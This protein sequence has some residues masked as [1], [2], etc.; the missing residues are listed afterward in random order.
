MSIAQL[1]TGLDAV[2]LSTNYVR[3]VQAFEEVALLAANAAAP[4]DDVLGL[5][6]RSMCDLIGVSRCSVYL[7]RKDGLFQGQAGHSTHHDIDARVKKLVAGGVGD[8]FTEE[9]V[10]TAAPVIVR[11]ATED[12]RTL[13]ATMLRWGVCD[14]LG[15]PL[16]LKGDVI[17]I[18][19][20][21]NEVEPHDYGDEDVA[22]A[23]AFAGL[24]ALVVHQAWTYRRL[25]QRADLIESQRRLL[26]ESSL[27]H[28]QVMQAMVNGAEIDEILGIIVQ[29][30]G[31]P[32][33][34]YGPDVSAVAFVAPADLRHQGSPGLTEDLANLPWVRQ[35]LDGLTGDQPSVMLRATPETKCR[36]LF[37]AMIVD[38]ECAGYLELCEMATP[39]QP[40]DRKALE[41]V[42]MVMALKLASSRRSEEVERQERESFF[43]DLIYRRRD[44]SLL[45]K[46]ADRFK[47]DFARPHVLLRLQY[48][49]NLD[50]ATPSSALQ[51]TEALSFVTSALAPQAAC[52][53]SI[54][55][56]GAS[57]L[58]L[59][60][61]ARE[62]ASE[63]SLRGV[64]DEE[65]DELASRFGVR[66]LVAS[67]TCRSIERIAA[68]AESVKQTSMVLLD[69]DASARS[70]LSSELDFVRLVTMSGGF[71][72]AV[73]QVSSWL[74][75][76]QRHDEANGGQLVETLRQFVLHDAQIRGA[77][78]ALTVH[79][80]TVRYR[81]GKIKEMSMFAPE[82]LD[83]ALR[84]SL[85]FQILDFAEDTRFGRC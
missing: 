83:G 34:F 71:A 42:S 24:S 19:Y 29:L 40:Q 2:H 11:D 52:V 64:L 61:S 20:L 4:L 22:L 35:A 60:L 84:A 15:V 8:R 18:I 39:F 1:D 80:N 47:F 3:V 73:K 62:G 26:D 58:L 66:Y 51:H 79:E 74:S 21:D 72:D 17:G 12:P 49:R 81:L 68:E 16:V 5:V 57:L 10:K 63:T 56:P 50:D 36:R 59:E 85:A 55:V 75:P 70:V 43:A 37:T 82:A 33:V 13:R 53:A 67:E 27:V 31:K 25:Q 69:A 38:G 78:A 44:V 32:A 9:I 76:L 41:Q 65:F 77:A 48:A 23:Q 46:R 45:L 54:S 7:R 6:G 14:M 30:L 28:Q